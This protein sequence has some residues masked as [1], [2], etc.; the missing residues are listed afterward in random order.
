MTSKS[1]RK[2]KRKRVLAKTLKA[3]QEVAP[4][5]KRVTEKARERI[6]IVKKIMKEKGMKL[7]EASKYV[8]EHNLWKPAKG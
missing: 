7:G 4:R 2:L 8:K 5:A 1:E 3:A 6:E